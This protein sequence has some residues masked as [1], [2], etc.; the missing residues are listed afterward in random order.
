MNHWSDRLNRYYRDDD[1]LVPAEVAEVV[2]VNSDRIIRPKYVSDLARIHNLEK[3]SPLPGVVAYRYSQ[4]KNI[5][6]APHR[7]RRALANPSCNALRQRKFKAR[8]RTGGADRPPA[9]GGDDVPLLG[10]LYN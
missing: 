7:G 4:V 2:S 6:V 8:R 9:A 3:E 1:L 10:V 5:K